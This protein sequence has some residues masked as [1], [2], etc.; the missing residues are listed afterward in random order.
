MPTGV[1]ILA[2]AGQTPPMDLHDLTAE[3]RVALVA[4][5]ELVV[6]SDARVSDDEADRLQAV[7]A[8]VG[9]DAYRAAA[10][11]VDHRFASEEDARLFLRSI[12]NQEARELIYETVLA[13]ALPGPIDSR[14]SGLLDWLAEAWNIQT[15][16]E[17]EE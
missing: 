1:D 14:E 3:E 15:R 4:L 9:E 11:E 10:E 16:P 12:A 17:G 8:A 2:A 5:L 13:A 6:E 7:I